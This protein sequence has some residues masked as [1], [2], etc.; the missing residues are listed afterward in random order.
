MPALQV[1]EAQEAD[2]EA[3]LDTRVE[4]RKDLVQGQLKNGLKYVI[5]PNSV[6]P[7]RF[8]AHL[9]ICAGDCFPLLRFCFKSSRTGY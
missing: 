8:E 4:H 6:P 3:L 5:L 2:V 7:E 1:Q 9:E